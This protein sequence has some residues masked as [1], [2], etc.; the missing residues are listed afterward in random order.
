MK[1]ISFFIN[2]LGAAGGTQRVLTTL[3]N[4]LVED[5]LVS[6]LILNEDKPFFPLNP[7]VNLRLLKPHANSKAAQIIKLNKLIYKELKSSSCDYYISLDSNSILFQSLYLPRK[8]R[9]L[10]WE[11]FSLSKNSN[12]FLFRISRYYATKRA[13]AIVLLSQV[14][15]KDWLKRYK[16][17]ENKLKHIYNPIT[18]GEIKNYDSN[19]LYANKKVLAIGNNI[20]V[21]GFDYLIQAWSLLEKKDWILEIIGLKEKE[22]EMLK[23]LM[24][25]YEFKNEVIIGGRISDIRQKYLESSIYCLCSRNEATPLVIIESQYAGLPAV[26]FDNCP[27]ALELLNDSGIVVAYNHV[28]LLSKAIAELINSK[29]TFEQISFKAKQNADRFNQQTFKSKWKQLLN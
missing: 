17:N 9:L 24:A 25:A 12:K 14:E 29:K 15:K 2:T 19:Q 6:I 3:A 23:D 28:H 20:H 7:R 5:Y 10:V 27:G 16:I 11:H 21:K 8:T 22:Q 13:W 4:L 1:S 18:I 26:L